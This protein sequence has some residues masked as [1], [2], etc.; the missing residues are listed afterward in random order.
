MRMHFSPGKTPKRS[1]SHLTSDA[2]V[3]VDP[4]VWTN[5]CLSLDGEAG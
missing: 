5:F 2:R 1:N 3:E 4:I